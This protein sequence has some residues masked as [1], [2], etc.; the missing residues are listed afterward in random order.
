MVNGQ[1][2]AI[3]KRNAEVACEQ[4]D[5][6]NDR[7]R[8]KDGPYDEADQR[9]NSSTPFAPLRAPEPQKSKQETR[10]QK[11]QDKGEMNE[12]SRLASAPF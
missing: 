4:G 5:E 10:N 12:K 6:H 1:Q 9:K 7:G 11:P 3:S 2:G 8:R